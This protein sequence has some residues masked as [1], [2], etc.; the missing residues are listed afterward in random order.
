[1]SAN[2]SEPKAWTG[3]VQDY[4]S[5][6]YI[7]LLVL[8]IASDSIYYGMLGINILSYSS[9]LDVLLSP[10]VHLTSSPIFPIVI[11]LMPTLLY[12]YLKWLDKKIAKSNQEGGAKYLSPLLK[13]YSMQM[14]WIVFSGWI[15]FSAYIGFGFGGG[16]KMKTIL[17]SNDFSTPRTITFQNGESVNAKILGNNSGYIFYAEKGS[18][19]VIVAPLPGNVRKIE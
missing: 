4:L 9:V 10:I 2:N 18:S 6:G 15:V 14:V 3:T 19:N 7:Y 8:G 12:F 13:N 16:S 11:I 5:L 17:K 1:M